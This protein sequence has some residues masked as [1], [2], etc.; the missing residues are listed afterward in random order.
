MTD[1][2]QQ[3]LIALPPPDGDRHSARGIGEAVMC[4]IAPALVNALAMATGHRF[5][6]TPITPDKIREALK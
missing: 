2:P 5:R 1:V 4:P 3:E 6:E